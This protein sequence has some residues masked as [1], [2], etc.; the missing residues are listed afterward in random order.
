MKGVMR[1]TDSIYRDVRM[2]SS[3]EEKKMLYKIRPAVALCALLLVIS[4]MACAPTPAPP[5]AAPAATTAPTTA[6]Q[7]TATLSLL[8][9]AK[10]EGKVSI[11]TSLNAD[12]FEPIVKEFSQKY[13]D[14][15]VDF[16]RGSSEDVTAKALTEFR[17]NTFLVDVLETTDV[18]V[19][20]LLSA[21]VLG[22]YKS[23]EQKA[24]PASAIDPDGYYTADRVNLT[25]IAYNTSLVK[26]ED[27]PKKLEDLL[28]PKWAGGKIAIEASD[29]PLMAYTAKVWGDAKANDF[30]TKLAAQKPRVVV[31]H[32]EL[33]NFLTAGEFTVSPTVY[34]HRIESQKAKKAPVEWVKTD[35]VYAFPHVIAIAKNVVHSNAAKV[36]IDWFL[37]EAGQQAIANVG[38]YPVRPGIKTNPPGLLDGLNI[39]YGDPKSLLKA[40][41]IQKQYFTLFGIK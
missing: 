17:A 37:S 22:Q 12:E 30:W 29:F 24:Y 28:D 35:P 19:A 15:K 11:Y 21:G 40:D 25:V 36:W 31:G 34:A 14:I 27:A 32:T 33:V 26:K 2:S 6:P 20:Q 8:D 1:G 41:D 4:A 5:T 10:K 39:F 23:P 3:E 9:A 16:W 38:R 18:N 7:P 13:P